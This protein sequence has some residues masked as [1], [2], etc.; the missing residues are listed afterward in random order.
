M[1]SDAP[2]TATPAVVATPKPGDGSADVAERVH[3]SA[4]EGSPPPTGE[5]SLVPAA[6]GAHSDEDHESVCT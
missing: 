4:A 5:G 3:A 2:T 6:D 1:D